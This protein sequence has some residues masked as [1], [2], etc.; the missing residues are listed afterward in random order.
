M[1]PTSAGVLTDVMFIAPILTIPGDELQFTLTQT[2]DTLRKM[3]NSN[4]I[5]K[6]DNKIIKTDNFL[7]KRD[8]N[9]IRIQLATFHIES[10]D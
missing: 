8:Y 7:I 10:H 3:K 2:K 1:S 5:R 6:K 9:R 4:D